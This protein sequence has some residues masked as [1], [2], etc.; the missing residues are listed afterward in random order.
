MRPTIQIHLST[1][2]ARSGLELTTVAAKHATSKLQNSRGTKITDTVDALS[3][4]VSS[5][6]DTTA[7]LGTL[8][9]KIDIFMRIVDKAASVKLLPL[10]KYRFADI[11]SGYALRQ[12]CMEFNVFSVSSEDD[13][14][15]LA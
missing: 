1:I 8:L 4:G 7:A 13:P 3:S 14:Q 12:T 15:S 9:E 5:Q 6:G 10:P 11:S 2:D